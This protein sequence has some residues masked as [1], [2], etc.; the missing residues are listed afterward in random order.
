MK[1]PLQDFPTLVSNMA[2][3]VQG[4]SRALIDLTVG[5]VLRAV[6]EANASLALWLQ[7][8]IVQLLL[9]TRAA[10][11][12]G[13]D[14]DSWVADFSVARLP[15][16]A[17]SGQ[18][19]F[20]RFSPGVA[21]SIPVG[22]Q[23]RTA[24][25]TTSFNVVADPTNTAFDP[26]ANAFALPPAATSLSVPVQ[27]VA[28]GAAGNV[29][30][31][32]IT[33]LVDALPG[34]DTVDNPA[35]LQ[36]GVDGESDAALRQRFQSWAASLARATPLAIQSAI[37]SVQ[38]N[39]AS[40]IA[41]GVDAAGNARSGHFVVIVDD[42]SGTPPASLLSTVAGAVDAVRPVGTT[43]DVLAPLLVPVAV[44]LTISVA[45]GVS[46]AAVVGPVA[47]AISA[48][49]NALPIGATLPLTRI[50]TLAYGASSLV[51]NVSQVTLNGAAADVVPAGNGVIKTSTVAV[52]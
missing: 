12:S 8:L 47:A 9:T 2:A 39:L 18:V 30:A 46:K 50:A 14:L 4:A 38:Q 52:N 5:S 43:Y 35:P 20:A 49:V 1:L 51:T 11:S 24:D 3:G 21:A 42:G 17:A 13:A 36:N 45:A 37:A 27:A 22:T 26:V 29:Q 16:V 48:W 44:S 31:N 15:G 34:V 25:G 23:V 6:L 19:Q 41:E 10:T 32:A 7:W 40:V 28:A 33:L